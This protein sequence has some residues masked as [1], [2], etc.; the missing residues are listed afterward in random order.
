MKVSRTNVGSGDFWKMFC[1]YTLW[2]M[3]YRINRHNAFLVACPYLQTE[4]VYGN[5]ALSSLVDSLWG[6]RKWSCCPW[7]YGWGEQPISQAK[8]DGYLS[9]INTVSRTWSWSQETYW[10]INVEVHGYRCFG[11]LREYVFIQKFT[12]IQGTNWPS[13]VEGLLT[14]SVDLWALSCI[15]SWSDMDFKNVK[16]I[17]MSRRNMKW[18]RPKKNDE[19]TIASVG[20]DLFLEAWRNPVERR[21][22]K[23][24]FN[25]VSEH[26]TLGLVH[27]T[28]HVAT[29]LVPSI[30]RTGPDKFSRKIALTRRFGGR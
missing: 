2:P 16:V 21:W 30:C 26:Q 29:H 14:E 25:V 7:H 18:V 22:P 4:C 17:V 8:A 11:I 13:S 20:L 9:N 5:I 12:S 28:D 24:G 1:Q 3:N 27:L 19:L 10:N 6:D 15:A 23:K